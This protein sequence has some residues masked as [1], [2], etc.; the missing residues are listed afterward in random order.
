MLTTI[1]WEEFTALTNGVKE[2]S[3][4]TKPF[5]WNEL[6]STY[7]NS[8]TRVNQYI[9]TTNCKFIA[10]GSARRAYFLPPGA[11]DKGKLEEPSCFKVAKD[12]GKGIAQNEAEV[13]NLVENSGDKYTC[14]PKLYDW[15]ENSYLFM[16]CEVGTPV[17]DVPPGI[18]RE[19]VS[20]IGKYLEKL[21]KDGKVPEFSYDSDFEGI[22]NMSTFLTW[23]DTMFNFN[24]FVDYDKA[25]IKRIEEILNEIDKDMPQYKGITDTIRL[26]SDT[27]DDVVDAIDFTV[28]SN[29]AFVSRKDKLMMLPIDWGFTKEVAEEYY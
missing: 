20:T 18:A 19:Y 4:P 7:S 17:P 13:K 5:R 26:I 1:P 6:M 15:E 27:G 11:Y 8:L 28:A 22:S 3:V 29:W 10:D 12:A 16:L 25:K 21:Y 24:D 2:D 14:F 9:S 23:I